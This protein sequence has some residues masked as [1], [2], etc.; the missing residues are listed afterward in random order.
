MPASPRFAFCALFASALFAVTA[1]AQPP[2]GPP[3]H[4]ERRA[5]PL[6]GGGVASLV[7][8][9]APTEEASSLALTLGDAPTATLVRGS[10]P[11]AIEASGETLLVAFEVGGPDRPFC[12]RVARRVGAAYVLGETHPL[13]RPG[14]RTGDYPFAVVIAPLPDGFAVFF[15]EVEANDPS[16][17]RTYL[18]RLDA[19]G[20]PVGPGREIPVPWPLAAAAWNGQGFHLALFYPGG[21]GGMR[22]SMV[23]VTAEGQPQQHPDWSSAAGFVADVHLVAEAGHVR[24]FYRGGAAGDRLLES[25][26][27]AVRSWGS[28]PPRARDHGALGEGAAITIAADGTPGHFTLH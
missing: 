14:A 11:G 17:A 4:I 18:F 7:S 1:R 13:A 16:A 26:V 28:E 21:G 23:S 3:T 25:D 10:A 24:A 9:F 15:E 2:D 6:V 27:T 5:V 22:L 19:E 12:T 8:T 20:V